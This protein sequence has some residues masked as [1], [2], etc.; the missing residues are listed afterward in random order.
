MEEDTLHL[1]V[2]PDVF[3]GPYCIHEPS[4]AVTAILIAGVAL[5][6]WRQL[7]KTGPPASKD[8]LWRRMFFLF[9]GLGTLLGGLLGHAMLHYTGFFLGKSMGWVLGMAAM[10][11]LERAAIWHAQPLLKLTVGRFLLW[12]NPLL[13][14]AFVAALFFSLNFHLVEVQ[15]AVSLLMITTPL[16]VFILQKTGDLS[17]RQFLFALPWAVLAALVAVLKV[18]PYP[19]FTHLDIG[20]VFMVL[21]ILFLWKSASTRERKLLPNPEP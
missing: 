18:C 1:P 4:V 14:L 10:S 11:A 2:Q 3:V 7:S 15:A 8:V 6:A 16:Q 20:H 5:L 13:F 17:S 9:M 19:W 12:L 21:C